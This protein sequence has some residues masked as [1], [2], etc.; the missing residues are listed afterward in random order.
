MFGNFFGKICIRKNAQGYKEFFLKNPRFRSR[1][2]W[3]PICNG[4]FQRYIL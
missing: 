1:C 2:W 3:F 4:T